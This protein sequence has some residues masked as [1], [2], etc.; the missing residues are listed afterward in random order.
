VGSA[1]NKLLGVQLEQCEQLGGVFC[2][3]TVASFPM[4][5]QVLDD[6]E[7]MPNFCARFPTP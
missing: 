3:A 2:Q 6:M 7:R 5:E 1:A 4:T